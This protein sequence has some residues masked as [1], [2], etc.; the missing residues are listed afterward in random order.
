MVKLLGIRDDE[1]ITS[2]DVVD[3]FLKSFTFGGVT[4]GD[5]ESLKHSKERQMANEVIHIKYGMEDMA[6]VWKF[7]KPSLEGADV[8][9]YERLYKFC[10]GTA[11]TKKKN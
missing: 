1:T 7:L 11:P 9:R 2:A 8:S 5:I 3:R 4:K 6:R 10:T